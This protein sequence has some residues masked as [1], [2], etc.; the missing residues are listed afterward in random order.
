MDLIEAKIQES[1]DK[2]DKNATSR[3]SVEDRLLKN[4]E[5][6]LTLRKYT[7]LKSLIEGGATFNVA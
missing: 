1:R 4:E 6:S 5:Y 2:V 7:V 3:V